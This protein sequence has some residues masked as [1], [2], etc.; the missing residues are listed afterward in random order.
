MVGL[1][2]FPIGILWFFKTLAAGFAT[3]FDSE[4][5]YLLRHTGTE[6]I[7]LATIYKI[8]LTM[9]SMDNH[10]VWKIGY[11][12]A[13]NQEK[14]VRVLPRYYGF[15][16]SRM[17]DFKEAVKQQNPTVTITNWSHSFDFDQ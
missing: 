1:L 12:D 7:P 14:A 6:T 2:L 9:T 8:K 3:A 13:S 15:F 11:R 16:R 5:L 10:S 4:N 17:T